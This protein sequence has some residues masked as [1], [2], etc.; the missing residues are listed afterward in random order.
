MPGGDRTGPMG[1]G[2]M[3]GRGA[4]W[5]AG[6]N[7]PGYA[8]PV[9]GRG[10]MGYGRGMGRG[11]GLGRGYGRGWGRGFAWRAAGPYYGASNL[12]AVTPQ[13]EA[14][15]LKNQAQALQEEIKAI[16]ARISELESKQSQE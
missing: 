5:C 4:G 12:P 6:Y 10:G 8:N 16:N 13:D 11:A 9:P 1:A 14:N 3:S 2:P 15:I 7:T